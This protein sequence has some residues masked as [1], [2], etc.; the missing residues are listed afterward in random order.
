MGIRYRKLRKK[1]KNIMAKNTFLKWIEDEARDYEM[2]KAVPKKK[3]EEQSQ[4]KEEQSQISDAVLKLVNVTKE[5]TR[6]HKIQ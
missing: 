1:R 4:K 3:K 2:R 5:L 6:N